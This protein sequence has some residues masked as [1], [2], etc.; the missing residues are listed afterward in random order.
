MK[1]DGVAVTM[2]Y[3]IMKSIVHK[4]YHTEAFC[5]YASFDARLLQD[6]EGRIAGEELERLMIAAADFTGD[7]YFGLHQG[8][9]TEFVDLGILG[10]VMM[11][12]KT[13]AESLA[14]YQ[15]YNVILCSGF[16]LEWEVQGSE[17]VIRMYLQHPG[18]MSRH[19]VED[20][21]SS[22][23]RLI[24]RLGNRHIELLGIQFAHDAPPD[25]SPYLTVFGQTPSFGCD[26]NCLRISRDIL[27][28]SVLYSDAKLL[29]VFA[30]IAEE[31]RGELTEATVLSERVVQWMKK[32]MPAFFP[33]LQQTAVSFGTSTR[34]LQN[35][36]K[37]EK[38]TFNDLSVLVRKELAIGYLRKWEYS[39]GEIAYALHFSEPSAF[40][41]A[42]KKWTGLTPSQY[43]ANMKQQHASKQ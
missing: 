5:Q 28:Y 12:S 15:R 25:L 23:Y 22:L 16:N 36:L 6:V 26:N 38:T 20:M 34:T 7:D 32:S 17:V 19:C 42:F 8:A 41:S 9:M 24:G 30:A 3:P 1:N 31:T 13:I 33:S 21:A 43:R 11:H 14:A 35:K 10:Y 2:V 40:Q 39:V 27:D 37:E 18:Q 4:G 29:S